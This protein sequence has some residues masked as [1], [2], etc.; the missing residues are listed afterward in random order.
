MDDILFA[1]KGELLGAK[2]DFKM[3]WANCYKDELVISTDDECARERRMEITN[4]AGQMG[5]IDSRA[6]V[7]SIEAEQDTCQCELK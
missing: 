3:G 2:S 7:L 5:R 1:E 6:T 4:L